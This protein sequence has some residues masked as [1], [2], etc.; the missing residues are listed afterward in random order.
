MRGT[1]LEQIWLDAWFDTGDAALAMERVRESPQ[2]DEFLPGNRRDDGSLRYDETTYL[3]IIESY[4][5]TLLSV[6]INPDI[7]RHRFAENIAGLRSPAEFAAGVNAVY[8]RVVQNIPQ[9]AEWAAAEFGLDLTPEAMV[10]MALDPDIGTAILE[11]RIAMAEV[12]GAAASKNFTIGADLAER[13]VQVGLDTT[14]EALSLFAEA[15]T[16]VPAIQVLARRHADPDDTFDLTEFTNAELFGDPEERRRMRRLMAI[17]RA[18]FGTD[19]MLGVASN[20]EGS[21]TGLTER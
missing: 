7:F 8:E 5:D 17:E 9:T 3:G 21:L 2:Y 16:F 20:Q 14:Q 10:A 1:P 15:E 11:R 19:R 13:M 18:G 6:N 12:G 4:E